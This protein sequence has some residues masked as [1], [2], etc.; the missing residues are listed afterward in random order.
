M[1]FQRHRIL[2]ITFCVFYAI[3]GVVAFGHA[4]N[5]ACHEPQYKDSCGMERL[6]GAVFGFALWPLYA[7]NKIWENRI[8]G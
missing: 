7:S 1:N 3:G 8:N 6:I 4:F 2:I 5:Q